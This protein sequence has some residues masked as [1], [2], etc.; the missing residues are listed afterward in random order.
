MAGIVLDG[1][2]I[3]I[4]STKNPP[5]IVKSL[6]PSL[7]ADTWV[8]TVRFRPTYGFDG[9]GN[10]GNQLSG[11][12]NFRGQAITYDEDFHGL[13]TLYAPNAAGDG[14]AII[15]AVTGI[16]GRAIDSWKSGD[17]MWLRDSLGQDLSKRGFKPRILTYGYPSRLVDAHNNANLP[18]YAKEFL[19]LVKQLLQRHAEEGKNRPLILV[20]HSFGGLII[21]QAL[22]I[23]H[24]EKKKK[25]I[26]NLCSS[27]AYIALFGVPNL[28]LDNEA[29]LKMTKGQ[30]NEELIQLLRFRSPFL[31]ELDE[32]FGNYV[33]Q[34]R[35]RIMAVYETKDSATRRR[36][37]NGDWTRDGPKVL[38]VP[39]WSACSEGLGSDVEQQPSFYSHSE[40]AKFRPHD[41]MY[42]I[43]IDRFDNALMEERRRLRSETSINPAQFRV[44]NF[45]GR[46]NILDK[47]HSCLFTKSGGDHDTPQTYVL[48]GI[49]GMGKTAIARQYAAMYADAYAKLVWIPAGSRYEIMKHLTVTT[50]APT[51]L[52]VKS[53]LQTLSKITGSV[54]LVYDGL[55]DH[56][57]LLDWIKSTHQPRWARSIR[58]L[59]TTC[60]KK[61]RNELASSNQYHSLVGRLDPADGRRLLGSTDTADLESILG[62]KLGWWPLGLQAVAMSLKDQQQLKIQDAIQNLAETD[63]LDA[64]DN[65]GLS[66][67]DIFDTFKTKLELID[68]NDVGY[69][70][71]WLSLIGFFGGEAKRS[72]FDT[73]LEI[74]RTAQDDKF[75]EHPSAQHI[76]WIL[77]DGQWNAKVIKE[78][79]G[80]V[81]RLNL[82][83]AR[84][85]R[86]VLHPMLAMWAR[87]LTS[88]EERLSLVRT[89]A[90][91]LYS[92]AERQRVV[93]KTYA[94]FDD[95][96]TIQDQLPLVHHAEFLVAYCHDVLGQNIAHIIPVECTVMFASWY[97]YAGKFDVA[98]EMLEITLNRPK[99]WIRQVN[100]GQPQKRHMVGPAEDRHDNPGRENHWSVLKAIEASQILAFAL[101]K[102]DRGQVRRAWDIQDQ[103]IKN[104]EALSAKNDTGESVRG[105]VKRELVH[106]RGRLVTI[107]NVLNRRSR[108]ISVQKELIKDA[109]ADEMD[110]STLWH[111]TSRLGRLYQARGMPQLA[112]PVH[113]KNLKDYECHR[114]WN[115]GLK[116]CSMLWKLQHDLAA[117]YQD[118]KRYD[119][120]LSLE[121]NILQK[122]QSFPEASDLQ[123]ATAMYRLARTCW[124]ASEDLDNAR[125]WVARAV[126]IHRKYGL[127]NEE[128]RDAPSLM[129]CILS[130]IAEPGEAQERRVKR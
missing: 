124:E 77:I 75:Q 9:R 36:H 49:A 2:N 44:P 34:Y 45:Q 53:R 40:M 62:N 14:D 51:D 84:A 19:R 103:A 97:I 30:K 111:E 58:V 43:L 26:P 125:I 17:H 6:A 100:G 86:W 48:S 64:P 52:A 68:A 29:F 114:S 11:S 38:V 81:V 60:N 72:I 69:A 16:G 117:T 55:N 94:R 130:E 107:S 110:R 119:E 105:M 65:D 113:E 54:L 4:P 127:D 50:G 42:G 12:H 63:S 80:H 32:D 37:G 118:L 90:S 27:T 70:K 25:G 56:G 28:G 95:D 88:G 91:L 96:G 106:A 39:Q 98:M 116:Y 83:E 76:S 93:T 7:V 115:R 109:K 108:I 31:E 102:S 3:Y 126:E 35:W 120:A 74:F 129:E 13:T 24:R 123:L 15:I 85:D 33:K 87:N 21:K 10:D 79:L 73:A 101:H 89:V 59:I 46:Q 71:F 23:A 22:K 82:L 128:A 121:R 8:A 5:Q 78:K 41:D 20:G 67:T 92:S 99:H 1:K 122:V 112:L 66:S 18:A 104:L 61:V 47:I 57:E